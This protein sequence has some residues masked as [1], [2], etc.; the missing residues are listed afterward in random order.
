MGGTAFKTTSKP[1]IYADF[2]GSACT[3]C[4]HN[5][6]DEDIK[7]QASDIAIQRMKDALNR[8]R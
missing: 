4:G 6:T 1:Q 3:D 7:R 8:K 5:V 2:I